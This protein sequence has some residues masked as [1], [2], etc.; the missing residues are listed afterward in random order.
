MAYTI[1]QNPATYS[2]VNAELWIESNDTNSSAEAYKY[3]YNVQKLDAITSVATKL[4]TYKVPPRPSTGNGLFTPNKILR[5][6]VSK[7]LQPY[8][9]WITNSPESIV[10]Y[11]YTYGYEYNINRNYTASLNLSG[12][13]GLALQGTISNPFL[14]GDI[15]YIDKT[16]KQSNPQYDGT[17]SVLSTFYQLVFGVTV[18]YITT[19]KTFVTSS[20]SD[21]GQITTLSR[22]LGTSSTFYAYN[23]TR[24]YDEINIDFERFLLFKNDANQ[25]R[26][27]TDFGNDF[28]YQSL[29][30][31]AD[32]ERE[33]KPIYSYQFETLSVL[34]DTAFANLQYS[35]GAFSATGSL[36]TTGFAQATSSTNIAY[37]RFDIPIGTANL[38]L[39]GIF[40]TT[41]NIKYYLVNVYDSLYNAKATK[42]YKVVDDCAPYPRR[43]RLAFQNRY[44]AFDYFNFNWKSVNT[45]NTNRTEFRKVLPFN[46][47]IGQRQDSVLAQKANETWTISTDWIT[48]TDSELF[49]QLITSPEVYVVPDPWEFYDNAFS[50]AGRLGFVS[51]YKH[52]FKVGDQITIKQFPGFTHASYNNTFRIY[53]IPDE[54]T[55]VTDGA[56][57]STTGAEGGLAYFADERTYPIMITDTSYQVKNTIDDKLFSFSITFRYAYD[58]N[59]QNN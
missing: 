1:T 2:P 3:V 55:V 46:Y 59:L 15:I 40:G 41:S 53:S 12:S 48:Q 44:G 6:Q 49:K 50:S 37:R 19:N 24:Q 31:V 10:K 33:G 35:I 56:F 36:L 11:N 20:T 45:I 27:L 43:F 57:V 58:I 42:F 34:Q 17:A 32:M 21:A 23:G 16:N 30:T 54:Y 14:V 5:S 52:N 51:R 39:K 29:P 26:F 18:S 47:T 9:Q 22:T 38:T 28:S 13:L 25:T 8:I 7:N 4:G